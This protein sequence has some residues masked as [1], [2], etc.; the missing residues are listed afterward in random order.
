MQPTMPAMQLLIP[1]AACSAAQ[2]RPV[3][4]ALQLP[5]LQ[6]LLASMQPVAL[7]AA[8]TSAAQGE[9]SLSPPHEVALASLLGLPLQDGQI[10]WAAWHVQQHGLVNEAENSPATAAWAFITPCH[11]QVGTDQLTLADPAA[12]A[13]SAQDGAALHAALQPYFAE[14]GIEL[15]VPMQPL[16]SGACWLARSPVFDG[17]ATASPSR[18]IA[19]NI[20][21]WMPE[22]AQAA[23]LR[24]LQNEMQMLLYTHPLND[25][26]AARGLLP[27]NSFWVHGAGSLAAAATAPADVVVANDL[28]GPALQQDWPAWARAWQQLDSTHGAALLAEVAQAPQDTHTLVLCGERRFMQF[29]ATPGSKKPPLFTRVKNFFASPPNLDAYLQL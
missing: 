8:A 18:V 24:R 23:P 1:Y 4:A 14:D 5:N 27:V 22:A 9:A 17:L 7:S 29:E 19:R 13:L 15:L 11:W 2:S 26:R 6:K 16:E 3:L 21:P 20:N 10:P 28:R 25:A 12:L